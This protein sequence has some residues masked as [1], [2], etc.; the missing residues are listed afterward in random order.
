MTKKSEWQ[1]ANRALQAEDRRTLGDPPTAEE[2]LA[3]SKGELSGNEA[4]RIQDLL[5]AYPELARMYGTPFPEPQPG[6]SDA[7]SEAEIAAG[8]NAFQQRLAVPSAVPQRARAET[9]RGVLPFRRYIVTSIA[10][11]VALVFCGLYIQTE[12]RAQGPLPVIVGEQ[13]ELEP[14]GTRGGGTLTTLHRDGNAYSVKLQ[15]FNQV[16]HPYYRIEL[17]DVSGRAIWEAASVQ[18][19]R[20]NAFHL[21]IPHAFLRSGQTYRLVVYGINGDTSTE[22]AVY[23]F[24]VPA[25]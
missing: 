7:V 20:Y 19:D 9:E 21:A 13:Q 1:D 4:E 5:V 22:A 8:W 23:P 14:G 6:D 2:M 16:R 17:L 11:A 24:A 12:R 15:L 3:Y 18:P 25:E 10:A